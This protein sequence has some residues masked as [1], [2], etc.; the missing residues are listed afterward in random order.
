MDDVGS[1]GIDEEAGEAG[2]DT[3]GIDGDRLAGPGYLE[4][5]DEVIEKVA[6]FAAGGPVEIEQRDG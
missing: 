4:E 6:V 5:V 3:G 2:A 1:E